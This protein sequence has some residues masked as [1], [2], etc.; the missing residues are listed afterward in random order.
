MNEVAEMDLKVMPCELLIV[1]TM[2]GLPVT[3]LT[4][5]LLNLL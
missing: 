1:I 4:F 3:I 2:K 5:I